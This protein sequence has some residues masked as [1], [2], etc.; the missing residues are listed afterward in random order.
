MSAAFVREPEIHQQDPA[1][2]FPHHVARF[3]VAVQKSRGMDRRRGLADV[4]AD[5]RRLRCA[6]RALGVD[7]L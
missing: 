6:E 1:A 4:D 3:D 2:G 5:Q 7:Q